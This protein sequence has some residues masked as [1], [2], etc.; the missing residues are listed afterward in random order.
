VSGI[1]GHAFYFIVEGPAVPAI[2]V[3]LILHEQIRDDGAELAGQH[4]RADV[5]EEPPLH[6]VIGLG[7]RPVAVFRRCLRSGIG[8]LLREPGINPFRQGHTLVDGKFGAVW[9][10]IHQQTVGVYI[11]TKL[12]NCGH[13]VPQRRRDTSETPLATNSQNAHSLPNVRHGQGAAVPTRGERSLHARHEGFR[14]TR[15]PAC[16]LES[17][18]TSSPCFFASEDP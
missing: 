7:Q 13:S 17:R 9:G 2:E 6:L 18:A 11:N 3:A 8:Q 12:R 4:P 16:A 10:R 14:L 15:A 1:F 5:G